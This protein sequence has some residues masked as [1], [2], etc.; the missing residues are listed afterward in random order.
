[1]STLFDQNAAMMVVAGLIKKPEIIHDNQSYKL[2]PNDFKS[3]FYKIIFGAINNLVQDGAQNINTKDIDLYIVQYKKQY[4]KYKSH[5]GYEFLTS[6]EPY[7]KDMDENKFRIHYDRTKKFTILRSLEGLGIDTKEFYNPDVNFLE[8]EKENKKLNKYTI[9]GILEKVKGRLVT[10]ENEYIARNNIQAQTAGKG[11]AQLYQGL[12]DTPEIGMPIEGDILN[13]IVRGARLGKMY[14]NSAP[15]GHGKTRFMIGNACALSVPRIENNKVVIKEDLRKTVIFTTEQKV[16][17]IQTLILA[18]VSG[19]NENKILTGTVD[20][21]EEKLIQKAINIIEFYDENLHIEVIGNPS[22]A[23]IKA[24]LLNYIT[25]YGIEYIFYDY[26]FSSPGLLG[27]FRDLK[28]RE[29]VALMMLSN[30][31]KEIAAENNVFIQSGTQLNDR[32]QK[33]LVRN[34]NHVRGSKAIGDKVDVGIISVMLSDVPEEKE[35][36]EK[37]VEAAN[38]PM[39]NI[40][41][42]VYKNR[43]GPLTGVKLFRHFDYGTC[44]VKDIMLTSS[45]FKVINDYEVVEYE[46]STLSFSEYDKMVVNFNE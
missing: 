18:Y 7:V 30:T 14:I 46:Q 11:M 34:V 24:R 22:I 21:Y 37:I 8:L 40:V 33:N 41:V 35:K 12:K 5:N 23:T 28:I 13:Y 31:L 36:V 1:M 25:K 6:L 29:D 38:V 10:V 27:E 42:D 44:R 45:S 43:R 9:E 19:V 32:W 15:S 16:D 2:T 4:E 20:A 39:P 26:I 3:D 17:E